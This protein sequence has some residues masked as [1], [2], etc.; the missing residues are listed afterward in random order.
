MSGQR[1]FDVLRVLDWLNA[2]GYGQIHLAAKGYGALPSTFAALL[3][4]HVV[5]VTLKN[6][7]SSY[8]EIAEAR[9]YKWPLSALPPGVLNSF[10]LPD[11]YRELKKKNVR[12][13][14]RGAQTQRSHDSPRRCFPGDAR[15]G[16]ASRRLASGEPVRALL[17]PPDRLGRRAE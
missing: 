14:N 15:N 8:A 4:P 16:R 7:L 17:R 12:C 1:T 11:C 9:D 6:A 5:Q 10:D 13:S 2:W 3:S